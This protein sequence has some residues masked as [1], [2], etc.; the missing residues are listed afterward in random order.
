MA[1]AAPLM[2]L[3]ASAGSSSLL[4][5]GAAGLSAIGSIAQGSYQSAV[6]KNNARIA[7][8]NAIMAQRDSQET[9]RRASIEGASRLAELTAAQAASGLDLGGR[10]FTGARALQQRSNA[11]EREDIGRRGLAEISNFRQEA[12]SLRSQASAAKTQGFF[13]AAGSI[14][15]AASQIRS[16]GSLL[17]SRRNG[18]R[19]PTRGK[20]NWYGRG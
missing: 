7:D 19:R 1:F 2:P 4:T 3:I 6:L 5:A 20:P 12:A 11:T 16:Q 15:G 14:L 10:S 9:A 18:G 17:K 13:D 8:A